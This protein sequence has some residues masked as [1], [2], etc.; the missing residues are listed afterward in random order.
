MLSSHWRL[1]WRARIQVGSSSDAIC[2]LALS[3]LRSF[4]LCRRIIISG[5]LRPRLTF[6]LDEVQWNSSS[7]TPPRRVS[8]RG[9]PIAVLVPGWW[10]RNRCSCTDLCREDRI[11]WGR[12]LAQAS[13]KSPS[14]YVGYSTMTVVCQREAWRGSQNFVMIH[15]S[16]LKLDWKDINY[17]H[18]L[19]QQL[20]QS[21]WLWP[22]LPSVPPC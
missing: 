1:N 11:H 6:R 3:T 13:S 14:G 8:Y 22:W 18:V 9:Q 7:C 20:E 16:K 5:N 2:W 4:S 12:W 21:S 19:T 17:L 15:R 10:G